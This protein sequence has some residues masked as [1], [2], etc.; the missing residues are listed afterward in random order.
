MELLLLS[1]STDYGRAMFSHA[2]EAF[3]DLAAGERVTFVPYAL[4]DWDGYADRAIAAL[5]AFGIDATSAHRPDDA[6]RAILDADVVM[7]GGGTRFGCSTHC[8]TWT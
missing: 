1:N 6:R 8:T 5:G 3:V 2:A 4:A 7:M